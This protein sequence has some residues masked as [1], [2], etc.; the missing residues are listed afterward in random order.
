MAA[1]LRVVVTW[2][3][4][5]EPGDD[6]VCAGV[7]VLAPLVPE[8]QLL[9]LA[10]GPRRILLCRLSGQPT[11]SLD[12]PPKNNVQQWQVRFLSYHFVRMSVSLEFDADMSRYGVD[13]QPAP[14]SCCLCLED[15]LCSLGL[16][17]IFCQQYQEEEHEEK[18]KTTTK[19]CSCIGYSHISESR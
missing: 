8:V 7:H 12:G 1:I 16:L 14:Y 11:H 18:E 2:A 15:V 17:V 4:T 5:G 6:C 3:L 13:S 19:Y 9:V 10:L